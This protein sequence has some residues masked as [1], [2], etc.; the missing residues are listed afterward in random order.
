IDSLFGGSSVNDR[1]EAFSRVYAGKSVDIEAIRVDLMNAHIAAVD[2]DRQGVIGL[3][4]PG[5]VFD[6]HRDVFA[7]YGLPTTTFGGTPFTGTRFESYVTR[8][9][10]CSRCDK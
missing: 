9:F 1:L 6:Y 3:L 7:R 2:A 10:W 5:Q 8:I 4:S